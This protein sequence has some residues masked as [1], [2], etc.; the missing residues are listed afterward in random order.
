MSSSADAPRGLACVVLA[1]ADPPQLRR[2][3]DALDPF[4]V[5]LHVDSRTSPAAFDA[6]TTGLPDRVTLLPRRPTPWARWGAVSAELDG[7]RAALAATD[8]SHVALLT[9]SDY[10]LRSTAGISDVLSGLAGR[11]IVWSR[12]LPIP[13]WGHG[14][15]SW[16]VRF[17]FS[18]WRK[19]LLWLPVPRRLPHGV[20]LAGGSPLKV[21]AREHAAALLAAVDARPDLVRRWR[22]T[23]APDETFVHSLLHT[24]S[25]VPGYEERSLRGPAW[26][27]RWDGSPRKSPPWLTSA[28]LPVLRRERDEPEDG[29]PK[30][31]ARKFSSDVDPDVLD[32][33]DRAFR[34]P[35]GEP[36]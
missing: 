32:H 16:R 25:M 5:F 3:V 13:E 26:V 6:M 24:P 30:L 29:V 14:G 1:H 36:A 4:P 11:S 34:Q 15:G 31:F 22:S 33:I 9:G 28:D 2:L 8:A 17:R 20:V 7:Y 23:W 18:A 21:L 10:P 12:R 35:A 27:I 19:H